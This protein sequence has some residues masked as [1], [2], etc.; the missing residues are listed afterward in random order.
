ESSS[1][2]LNRLSEQP[3]KHQGMLEK[4]VLRFFCWSYALP[5]TDNFHCHS[6]IYVFLTTELKLHQVFGDKHLTG[7]VFVYLHGPRRIVLCTDPLG[8]MRQHHGLDGGACR[9]RRDIVQTHVTL[10]SLSHDAFLLCGSHG[11]PATVFDHHLLPILARRSFSDEQIGTFCKFSDAIAKTGISRKHDHAIRRFKPI[12]IRLVLP[13]S[14]AFVESK[15]AVFNG[16]YLDIFVLIDQPGANIMTEEHIGYRR[17]AASIGD[18]DL[19]ADREI[20]HSGFN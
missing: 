10:S 14:Q 4:Q 11:L 12:G 9:H 17:G 16:S 5:S 2:K 18:S 3:A 8:Q 19:G 15:M 20:L 7:K 13:R 1:T 6:E